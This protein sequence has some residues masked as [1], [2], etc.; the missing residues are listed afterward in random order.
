MEETTAASEDFVRQR[1][2]GTICIAISMPIAAI[3]WFALDRFTPPLPGLETLEARMIFT[4][5]CWACA[6]LFCLV[7]GVEAVAHE[8][9]VSPSFDPL[10]N[11]ETRRLRVNLRYLQNTLEQTVAFTAALFGLA[12]FSQDGADMRAVLATAVVWVLARFAFWIGYHQSAAMRGLG[13]PG[14]AL[15]LLVLL[16]V[17][18]RFGYE[19]AGV[20]GA[21]APIAAFALIEAA[22]FWF[23]SRG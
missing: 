1:R 14:L 13:A 4:L 9:L 11:Y 23:T 3:I 12:A 8:R 2:I 21:V 17:A 15:S 22:L 5:K 19:L 7:T 6:V 16:Y 18:G 20:P 10:M